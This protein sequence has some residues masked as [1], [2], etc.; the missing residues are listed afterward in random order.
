MIFGGVNSE[1]GKL[2]QLIKLIIMH[3][4]FTIWIYIIT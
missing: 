1:M 2:N 4:L 3:N